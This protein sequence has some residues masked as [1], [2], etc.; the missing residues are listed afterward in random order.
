[1]TDR[2]RAKLRSKSGESIGETLVALLISALALVMLAG[3]ISSAARMIT[4]SK[5]KLS[6]YYKA[7]KQVV[8][9]IAPAEGDDDKLITT[10]SIQVNVQDQTGNIIQ[11]HS[12]L[13]YYSNAQYANKPVVL[14]VNKSTT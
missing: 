2:I 11:T 12:G 13:T 6:K 4:L 7:D 9:H 1:M 5:D 14:Y 8:E 10:G 3:A